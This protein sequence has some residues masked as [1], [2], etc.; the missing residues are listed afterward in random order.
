MSGTTGPDFTAVILKAHRCNLSIQ[1]S[2]TPDTT[3][4][5]RIG[6]CHRTS[7]LSRPQMMS[8]RRGFS[9]QTFSGTPGDDAVAP[10]A[11]LSA[12]SEAEAIGNFS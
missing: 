5:N 10:E 6:S 2:S 9:K 11:D 3:K 8:G 1:A 12:G 7:V 4:A